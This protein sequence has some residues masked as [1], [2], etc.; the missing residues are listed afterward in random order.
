MQ[1]WPQFWPRQHW[2]VF[3]GQQQQLI[4]PR[5]G[6]IKKSKTKAKQKQSNTKQKQSKAKATTAIQH[7]P[8][9]R[10]SRETI[11]S[12]EQTDLTS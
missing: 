5:S 8:S 9:T 12:I 1:F 2:I 11:E 3:G 7:K 4:L 10:T 6:A